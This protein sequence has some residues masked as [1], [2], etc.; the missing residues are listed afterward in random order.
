MGQEGNSGRRA[1]LD[2]KKS[3]AAGRRN[4]KSPE[5]QAIKDWQHEV[6]AKGKTAGAFGKDN[7]ANRG[8]S[9]ALRGGTS[10]RAKDSAVTTNRS[11]R[12]ARKR[13]PSKSARGAL[14]SRRGK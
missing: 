10:G 11:S 6:P 12:P 3:R 13:G 2:E 1:N 9:G 8:D 14:A 4:L 7:K 5:R